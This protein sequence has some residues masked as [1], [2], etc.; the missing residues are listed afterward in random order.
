MLTVDQ[1][2]SKAKTMRSM[3]AA[4]IEAYQLDDIAD[5]LE[6]LR[7]GLQVLATTFYKDDQHQ[8]YAKHVLG[9]TD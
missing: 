5:E 2:R 8:E 3:G 6:R 7:S 9:V 1:I 4:T